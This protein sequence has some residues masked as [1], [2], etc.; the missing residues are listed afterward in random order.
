MYEE[1]KINDA[2]DEWELRNNCGCFGFGLYFI[3]VIA[4]V[5]MC[6]SCAT[7]T[8]IEYRDRVVDNYITQV[9]HDT[10]QE[11]SSDSVYHE[12]IVRNDTVYNTK[13]KEKI[14]YRDRIVE[15]HDTCWRDSVAVEYKE[16]V[17]EVVKIPKIYRYSLIFSIIILIFV[18][19]KL[20]KKFRIL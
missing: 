11:Q 16:T 13:Y 5:L 12:V 3:C 1:R 18:G 4:F 10:L 14:K 9:V 17:K 8:K 7:R 6:T 15:R 2:W 20:Y 19:I